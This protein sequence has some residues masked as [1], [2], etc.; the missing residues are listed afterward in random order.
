MARLLQEHRSEARRDSRVGNA[1]ALYINFA[2]LMVARD[3][4][5]LGWNNVSKLESIALR[6]PKIVADLEARAEKL[7]SRLTVLETK[8]NGAFDKW[9]GHLSSQEKAVAIAE[10]A[11]NRLSNGAPPLDDLATDL[12]GEPSAGAPFPQPGAGGGAAS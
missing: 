7:D 4:E 10:D 5:R 3:R 1:L 9:D 2:R 6:A 8:G 12:P 11:I